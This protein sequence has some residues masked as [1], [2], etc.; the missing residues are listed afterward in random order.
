[1][2]ALGKENSKYD[3]VPK[4]ILVAVVKGIEAARQGQILV[5]EPAVE[6]TA[7]VGIPHYELVHV[8]KIMEEH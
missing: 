5:Q 1:M 3:D 6:I 8:R 7:F 2:N 4:I